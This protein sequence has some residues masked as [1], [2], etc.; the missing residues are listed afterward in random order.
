MNKHTDCNEK[1]MVFVGLKGKNYC[2]NYNKENMSRTRKIILS[3]KVQLNQRVY[4]YR[5]YKLANSGR[6]VQ[7][8]A[9]RKKW[10]FIL[11][12]CKRTSYSRSDTGS[13]F[14]V[15]W[16][17]MAWKIYA[18]CYWILLLCVIFRYNHTAHVINNWLFFFNVHGLLLS[19]FISQNTR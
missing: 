9:E 17:S 14:D 5:A 2:E 13:W 15:A 4:L 19:V 8:S 11:W 3:C 7:K 10:N 18:K 1:W 16:L 12:I 6:S